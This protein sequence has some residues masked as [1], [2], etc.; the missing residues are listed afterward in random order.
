[1]EAFDKSMTSL[2]SEMKTFSD[3]MECDLTTIINSTEILIKDIMNMASSKVGDSPASAIE[4]I[5]EAI[6]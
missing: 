2:S 5:V 1:M 6:V 4:D 3:K